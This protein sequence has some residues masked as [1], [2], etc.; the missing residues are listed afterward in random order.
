MSKQHPVR[1]AFSQNKLVFLSLFIAFVFAGVAWFLNSAP[2][3][4]VQVKSQGAPQIG[5]AFDMIDQNGN[6]FTQENLN[7]K[8]SLIFFGFTHCPDICPTG[9]TLLTEVKKQLTPELKKQVQI[10]FT[11]ID[12]ERDTASVL[13]SYL[14]HFDAEIIG[15]TG[16]K[17]QLKKMADAYLVYYAKN[18]GSDPQFYLMDH[19]AYVYV[20]DKSGQFITHFPH[21]DEAAKIASKLNILLK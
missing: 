5:G 11:T 15:L 13:K 16:S 18:P 3:K 2:V 9:L 17:Q 7:G 6:A 1:R 10:I 12:P 14:A 19:S 4:M 20:M 21:H 8:Y